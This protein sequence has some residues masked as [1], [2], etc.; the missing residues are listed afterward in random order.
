MKLTVLP[1]ALCAHGSPSGEYL[2]DPEEKLAPV[3]F[4]KPILMG[5]H[6]VTQAQYKQV[7][8]SNPSWFS[9]A[10]SGADDVASL[11]TDQF[12]VEQVSWSDAMQFCQRLSERPAEKQA[13]RKYRLPTEAEREYACR[14]GSVTPFHT[15]EHISPKFANIRGDRPYLGSPK[16][17]S[18]GRTTTVGSY[19]PNAFGL[20][21]MHGNVAEWCLDRLD[22]ILLGSSNNLN[23]LSIDDAKNVIGLIEDL[24]ALQNK[25]T[26]VHLPINPIGVTRGDPRVHR[27]GSFSSDVGFCRSASRREHGD[28]YRHRTI[29]F[30]VVCEVK[31]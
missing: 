17:P 28:D 24:I 1:A 19:P 15:G 4:S 14:A 9:T 18:L 25:D 2:R 12:P 26:E 22:G 16:G 11:K 27:G 31:Q 8:G 21:D 20:H 7:V 5:V 29:G 6:E 23:L 13:G 30:R 3:L 10:G